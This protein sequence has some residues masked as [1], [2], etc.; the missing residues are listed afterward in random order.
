MNREKT[1]SSISYYRNHASRRSEALMR[2]HPIYTNIEEI[3]E[4]EKELDKLLNL[5]EIWQIQRAK[6]VWLT[7]D[8]CNTK[9]FHLHPKK[10]Y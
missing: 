7:E 2:K 10:G 3:K 6:N 4:A 5:E 8:D 9:Y 1:F